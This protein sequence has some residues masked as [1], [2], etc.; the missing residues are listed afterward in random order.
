[1]D[2]GTGWER[3][4]GVCVYLHVSVHVWVPKEARKR[5]RISLELKLQGVRVT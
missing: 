2:Q 1:M 5:P 4:W 3:E